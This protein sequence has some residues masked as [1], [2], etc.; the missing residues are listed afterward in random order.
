ME[1]VQVRPRPEER[2]RDDAGDISKLKTRNVS[3]DMVAL[4]SVVV[5]R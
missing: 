5:V 2:Y 3:R 1:T 4:G